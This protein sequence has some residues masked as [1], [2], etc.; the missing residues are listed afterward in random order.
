MLAILFKLIAL[1]APKQVYN[2]L[3]FPIFDIERAWWLLF[4]KRIVRIKL[5]IFV[6]IFFFIEEILQHMKS[7]VYST[8]WCRYA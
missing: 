7:M 5:D 1:L 8:S 3:A 4:Q 2:Y 6:F